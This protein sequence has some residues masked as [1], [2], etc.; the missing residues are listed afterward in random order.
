IHQFLDMVT[1]MAKTG[2]FGRIDNASGGSEEVTIISADDRVVPGFADVFEAFDLEPEKRAEH[3]REKIV[4]PARRH[5]HADRHGDGNIGG[6][7]QPEQN[8]RAVA[9][10]L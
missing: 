4:K 7:D 8:G 3:D 6:A 5:G 2:R 10:L 9:E 1:S